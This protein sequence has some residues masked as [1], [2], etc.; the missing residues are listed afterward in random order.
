MDKVRADTIFNL[1][2]PDIYVT[3]MTHIIAAIAN[4]YGG[5]VVLSDRGR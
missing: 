2:L 4:G 5:H 3:N 1:A